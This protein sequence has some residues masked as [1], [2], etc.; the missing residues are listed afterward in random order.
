MRRRTYF[1]AMLASMLLLSACNSVAKEN[2]ATVQND[3]GMDYPTK[4]VQMIIPYAAGGGTDT[5][6][7]LV[8][9]SMEK[10]WGQSVVVANKAGG[11]GQVGLTELS[12]AKPDGYTLG[13]LSNL[14]HI[15]VLLTGENVSYTYDSFS[16][17]GAVNTTANVM[18]ASKGSGFVSMDELIEHAKENP[19]KITVAVSGKTHIA[20]VALLEQA[21]GIELTTVMQ[22]GGGDSLNAV[23]GGHV[24]C[25]VLD[26]NFVAQVE[27]QGVM[28]LA[29]F[30]GERLSKIPDIPTMKELGYN[31]ATE[32][33]RVFA[34]PAD[35]P[36]KVQDKIAETIRKVSE[37]EE[38]QNSM[39]EIGEIYRFLNQ[40]E[41]KARLD[42][43]Y[44]AMKNLLELN[45]DAFK[46]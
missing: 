46:Q 40:E 23:L 12:A 10:E 19:G 1:A 35:T 26:K 8:A 29:T 3:E 6:A 22:D 2:Q 9:A 13:T 17:L 4:N 38:F 36:Q 33:Y 7:R 25:A 42:Q 39:E 27:G 20:E 44:E 43:D 34:V 24:D 32:T 30:S 5:L 41:V 18:M 16:Y 31:V 37:K 45:P 21:A 15:L 11:L 28:V 14:D